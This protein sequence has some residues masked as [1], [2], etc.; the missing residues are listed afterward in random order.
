MKVKSWSNH[1]HFFSRSRLAI[2]GPQGVPIQFHHFALDPL[3]PWRSK[4]C[5]LPH[6]R[7]F[8]SRS[9]LCYPNWIRPKRPTS[10]VNCKGQMASALGE[11]RGPIGEIS[12]SWV[13]TRS[14]KLRFPGWNCQDA[15]SITLCQFE[16][17]VFPCFEFVV[18]AICS[19]L[20]P[21]GV[22]N[23]ISE[24]LDLTSTPFRSLLI[25]WKTSRSTFDT[26]LGNLGNLGCC[27]ERSLGCSW[28]TP[29]LNWR[30]FWWTSSPQISMAG[31]LQNLC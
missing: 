13:T 5:A 4:K 18:W 1:F 31:I 2:R 25:S 8:N 29:W 22:M 9:H 10:W 26:D 19:F 24:T 15:S 3:D 17:P 12:S 23:E 20:W 7:I 21:R 28:Y 16:C 14:S 27:S 6:P 30:L 11:L